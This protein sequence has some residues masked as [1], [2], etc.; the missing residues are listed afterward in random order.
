MLKNDQSHMLQVIN[1]HNWS[2]N[3]LGKTSC[4][5][6]MYTYLPC[7]NHFCLLEQNQFMILTNNRNYMYRNSKMSEFLSIDTNNMPL[8]SLEFHR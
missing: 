1:V 4:C 6:V 2:I 5:L 8:V 7:V 3:Q